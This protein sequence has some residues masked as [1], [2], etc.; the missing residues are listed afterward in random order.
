MTDFEKLWNFQNL[1]KAHTKAR[2]G[3]RN[4]TE[5]I[6][7]EMNLSSNLASLSEAIRTKTYKLNGYYSFMVY[8]PKEREIQ[9]LHY[10]D[11]VVQHCLCDEVLQPILDRR[12]IYDNAACRLDKGT[13]FAIRRVTLF[14]QK[15]YWK[16]GANGFVLKCDIRK[17]FNNIDHEILKAKLHKIVLDQ[18]ILW[19]LDLIIDS[20]EFTPGKGLPMGNQTSQWFAL[21][22]LDGFDRLIK[23]KLRIKYYSR[24]MDDCLLIHK[25]KEYLKQCLIEMNAHI[26]NELHL[27]FNEKTQ[28]FP[29][30]K[31]VV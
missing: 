29:D 14:L 16:Q 18:D 20:Y 26:Q 1:Y 7:F 8:D 21:Y 28:I 19:M 12:L 30:R 22:Y 23:E 13:L 31:S 10:K 25:D 17:Y 11:R 15:F 6:E 4:K 9:A 2:L 24:Y 3:K 5:V 27:Q